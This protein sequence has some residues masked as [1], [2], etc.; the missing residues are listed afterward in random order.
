MTSDAK[1]GVADLTAGYTDV[2]VTYA[3][4]PLVPTSPT[5][6]TVPNSSMPSTPGPTVS[7]QT[8]GDDAEA[9]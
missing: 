7:S 2:V 4:T 1:P 8:D 3:E 9:G 5:R 6:P